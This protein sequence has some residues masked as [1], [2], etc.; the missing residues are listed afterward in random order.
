VLRFIISEICFCVMIYHLFITLASYHIPPLAAHCSSLGTVWQ[1]LTVGL[2]APPLL[3]DK[4]GDSVSMRAGREWK[5]HRL[6]L[7]I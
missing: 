4:A 5:R 6:S 1:L 3:L 7:V 2:P